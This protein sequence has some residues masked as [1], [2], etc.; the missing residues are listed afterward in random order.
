MLDRHAVV[1][2]KRDGPAFVLRV[3]ADDERA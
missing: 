3:E 2:R 1:L